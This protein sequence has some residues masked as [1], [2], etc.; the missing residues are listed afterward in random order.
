MAVPDVVLVKTTLSLAPPEAL[1]LI[2]VVMPVKLEPSPLNSA[3][4]TIPEQFT[5]LVIPTL[6][7]TVRSVPTVKS[8]VASVTLPTLNALYATNSRISPL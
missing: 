2:P 1:T 7:P 4:V 8:P 3:A 6:P 5:L